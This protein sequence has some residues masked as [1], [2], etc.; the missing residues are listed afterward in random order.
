MAILH[1]CAAATLLILTVIVA[2]ESSAATLLQYGFGPNQS[3][4]VLTPDNLPLPAGLSVTNWTGS[5]DPAVAKAG[6]LGGTV[7]AAIG[8]QA[9]GAVNVTRQLQFAAIVDAAHQ[10]RI[11]AI[12]FDFCPN[13]CG[14]GAGG[15][16]TAG[17]VV[18]SVAGVTRGSQAVL[19][20]DTGWRTLSFAGLGIS[21]GGGSTSPA[22]VLFVPPS[23]GSIGQQ[24]RVDN[25]VVEGDIATA[26]AT[27]AV[28]TLTVL[29]QLALFAL[30]AAAGVVEA[31]RCS[32]GS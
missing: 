1:R 21:L 9:A 20:T 17:T 27:R 28:P 11:D 30:L 2:P 32:R 14:G 6:V 25:F 26:V 19:A 23:G 13:T 8:F 16:G 3:T 10:G 22:T 18:L 15:T 24:W 12:R 4:L 29:A 7:D 31:R 5:P